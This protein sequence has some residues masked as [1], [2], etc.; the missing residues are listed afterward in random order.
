MYHYGLSSHLLLIKQSAFATIHV[1]PFALSALKLADTGTII[2]ELKAN[3][4][5]PG[6]YTWG[7]LA[8]E[9]LLRDGHSVVPLPEAG[10]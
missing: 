1:S 10:C 8:H 6:P 9:T 3:Y 7:N 2:Y 5:L 4:I